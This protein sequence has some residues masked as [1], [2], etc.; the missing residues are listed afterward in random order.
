MERRGTQGGSDPAGTPVLGVIP[1]RFGSTRFPGK[2]LAPLHGKTILRRVHERARRIRGLDLLLVATD[3]ERI[4]AEVRSFGGEVRMTSPRHPSGSDRIGEVMAA[5]HPPPGFILNLQGDEPL[6]SPAAVGRL[7]ARAR[8]DPGAIWTLAD[9]IRSEEEFRRP[10]VVKVVCGREGRALYFSRAAVPFLRR[11]LPSSGG[12]GGEGSVGTGS[13]GVQPLRHVG[14][15]AY[16]RDLLERFLALP[17]APLE[18]AEGLEQLRALEAGIPIRVV[19]GGWPDAAIDTPEDLE[20]LRARYPR[21]QDLERA[22]LQEDEAFG[23]GDE[24]EV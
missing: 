12:R 16:P 17:P 1:A 22:G 10:S 5:L 24:Q 23:T 4:A 8:E 21:P 7:L 6:F 15:Y 11:G 9:P 18:E 20:R 14:V 13:P 19:V 3:D 2:L